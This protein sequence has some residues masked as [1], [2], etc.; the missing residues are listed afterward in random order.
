MLFQVAQPEGRAPFALRQKVENEIKKLE[1]NDITEN[2]TN[3]P[4]PWLNQL[5]V[6]AKG[7]NDVRLCLDMHNANTAIQRTRFPLPTVDDL[8][9]KL[10][11]AT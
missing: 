7:E 6:I 4:T 11:N 1:L 9:V 2:I 8:V 5:F 10:R 3:K